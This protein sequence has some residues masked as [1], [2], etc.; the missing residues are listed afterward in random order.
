M[1][2]REAVPAAAAGGEAEEVRSLWELS[3]QAVAFSRGDLPVRSFCSEPDSIR[4][5]YRSRRWEESQAERKARAE[6]RRKYEEENA[7]PPFAEEVLLC[8]QLCAYLST[9]APDAAAAP[10]ATEAAT[11]AAAPHS[12]GHVVAA[13]RAVEAPTA[14]VLVGKKNQADELSGL[15]AVSGGKASKQ[16]SGASGA[17]QSGS[18]SAG[19]AP[20]NAAA[21]PQRSPSERLTHSM[22]ALASFA[23]VG[24]V[25]PSTVG[26][27]VKSKEAVAAKKTAYLAKRVDA[28]AKREAQRA[29]REAAEAEGKEYVEPAEE[30][31]AD[32]K[33]SEAQ[34]TGE[35]VAEVSPAQEPPATPAAEPAAP[36]TPAVKAPEAE[37]K[38]KT[39]A[40]EA[41]D[42]ASGAPGERRVCVTLGVPA[43]EE[44][45]VSVDMQ[46]LV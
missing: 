31:A 13:K 10:G 15:Y 3:R 25:A 20:S 14:K 33:P 6:A 27:A 38:G 12:N 22:D 1:G 26:D 11:P 24:L 23:K 37:S 19:A 46:I 44:D 36:E 9:W 29:A 18:G 32:E 28:L 8:D 45:R 39:S 2:E 7:P 35:M 4:C 17:A 16:R 41:E 30:V 42:G 5:R 43:D 40:A 21:P 34:P